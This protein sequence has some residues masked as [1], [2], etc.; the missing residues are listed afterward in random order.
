MTAKPELEGGHRVLSRGRSYSSARPIWIGATVL[1]VAITVATAW[2]AVYEDGLVGSEYAHMIRADPWLAPQVLA[3]VVALHIQVA[4]SVGQC[5]LSLILAGATVIYTRCV[6]RAAQKEDARTEVLNVISAHLGV[7]AGAF[8]A[9]DP[10]ALNPS[11]SSSE[12]AT[13]AS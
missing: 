6:T 2:Y 9:S 4:I 12:W 11:Q 7:I 13:R 3:Q 8:S 5:C 10:R 1:L